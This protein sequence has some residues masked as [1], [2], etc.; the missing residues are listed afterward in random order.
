MTFPAL[1]PRRLRDHAG[2]PRRDA[3]RRRVRV[4]PRARRLRPRAE[5]RGPVLPDGH[6][7]PEGHVQRDRDGLRRDGAPRR[8]RRPRPLADHGA[9]D[10]PRPAARRRPPPRRRLHRLGLLPRHRRR[11]DGLRQVRRRCRRSSA[12][13]SARSLFGFVYGPLE[14]FYKSGAMGA[15]RIDTDC[16]A[17]RSRS[18]RPPSSRWRSAAFLGGEKLETIFAPRA[19]SPCRRRPRAQGARLRGLRGR[20]R[21]RPRRPRAPGAAHG[22]AAKPS[23]Q[24]G[25][26]EL[27]P[28]DRR[29]ARDS[30]WVVD[31]RG[32]RP[33]PRRADA[34][35]DRRGIPEG[36]AAHRRGRRSRRRGGSSS[37]RRATSRPR[38]KASCRSRAKSSSSPADTTPGRPRSSRR[39]STP[40]IPTPAQLADVPDARGPELLTSPGPPPRRRPRRPSARPV[41]PG[42]RTEERR[43]LLKEP[44]DLT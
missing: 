35:G 36:T 19:A 29:I 38:P 3:R 31:L 17:S 15:V 30:W 34:R 7:R 39:P 26:A 40:A 4:R 42:R 23:R 9:R 5:P 14:S 43:G 20:L 24:I 33:A 18:S 2:P 10:V 37:T 11:R 32:A 13:C 44:G 41:A 25:A 21:P 27:A 12:S 22:R 28:E 8:R 6:A 16:S 1:P